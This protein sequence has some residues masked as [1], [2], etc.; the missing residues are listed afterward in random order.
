MRRR[1]LWAGVQRSR[2]ERG[3]GHG[4]EVLVCH[5]WRRR[6]E[7]RHGHARTTTIAITAA[8]TITATTSTAD[9]GQPRRVHHTV[10]RW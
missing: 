1:T 5:G 6:F 8:I 3:R 4:R 2:R 7:R 9:G 10:A